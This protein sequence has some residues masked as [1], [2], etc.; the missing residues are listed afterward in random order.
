M[1][2]PQKNESPETDSGG[3]TINQQ[4]SISLGM[5]WGADRLARAI[6][7]QKRNARAPKFTE[8]RTTTPDCLNRWMIPE[9][10]DPVRWIDSWP[11]IPTNH[12]ERLRVGI[13]VAYSDM[14]GIA[15][16]EADRRRLFW[17]RV[18]DILAG[19]MMEA[20]LLNNK[21]L[22]GRRMHEMVSDTAVAAD[23]ERAGPLKAGEN[24]FG[25]C[26]GQYTV[27][28]TCIGELEITLRARVCYWRAQ[29]ATRERIAQGVGI[30][31]REAL[32]N[33]YLN[34]T[35]LTEHAVYSCAGPG[36]HS[37][38]KPEFLKWKKGELPPT[39]ATS[40]SLEAFLRRKLP[41][42]KK[43]HHT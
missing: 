1:T 4:R 31:E 2:E 24:R 32:L 14:F 36:T 39:S 17:T 21:V 7:E 25:Q 18:F 29:L 23:L 5:R 35:G 22:S 8:E 40:L 43:N 9:T 33:E 30:P 38:H 10:P 3:S 16:N 42:K 34:A 20:G 27:P 28:N 6:E 15:L 41:P 13:L 37:C 11:E 19:E 12:R 26:F